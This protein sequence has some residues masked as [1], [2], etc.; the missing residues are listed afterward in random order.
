MLRQGHHGHGCHVL[1]VGG[2]V[3][4]KDEGFAFGFDKID[5]A[6]DR[7]EIL[8]LWP[9]QDENEISGFEHAGNA[10]VL[11]GQGTVDQEEFDPLTLKL[12]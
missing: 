6:A 1:V 2:L 11:C 4:D 9:Y 3:Y 5:Q 7:V 10:F 12:S 8:A